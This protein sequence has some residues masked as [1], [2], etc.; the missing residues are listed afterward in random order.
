[1][2]QLYVF[3]FFAVCGGCPGVCSVIYDCRGSL[4]SWSDHLPPLLG[5]ASTPHLV[6]QKPLS[7]RWPPRLPRSGPGP[8][9]AASSPPSCSSHV[10]SRLP[11]PPTRH[12]HL[13]AFAPWCPWLGWLFQIRVW[14]TPSAPPGL[15]SDPATT[16]W[17]LVTPLFTRPHSLTPTMLILL[18]PALCSHCSWHLLTTYVIY[19]LCLLF[20]VRLPP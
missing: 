2:Y 4:G 12:S 9:C 19:L 3:F 8:L 16:T 6:R 10:A 13:G 7:S 15:C 17:P 5:T 18:D 11:F 1:M 20:V 14:P